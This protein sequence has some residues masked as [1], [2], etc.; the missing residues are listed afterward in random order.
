MV[1]VHRTLISALIA[2][3]IEKLPIILMKLCSHIIPNYY[4][5]SAEIMRFHLYIIP[6]YDTRS[7]ELTYGTSI[8][9]PYF[10]IFYY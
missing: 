3:L 10:K 7:T 5:A 4:T 9:F 8:R 2:Q 1:I 6:N